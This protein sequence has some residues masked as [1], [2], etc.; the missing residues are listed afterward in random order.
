MLIGGAG[1]AR[2]YLNRPEL[3]AE[4]FIKDPFSYKQGD[5][6]YKTGDLV[7]YLPDGNIEFMGR[8]DFQVKFRGFRVEPGEIERVIDQHPSVRESVVM[9]REDV[10]GQKFLAAYWTAKKGTSPAPTEPREFLKD[11]FPEYMVP[12]AFVLLEAFPLS[13][14][15][16]VDRKA[17]PVPELTGIESDEPYVGPRNQ[18]ENV[19]AHIWS[20]VLGIKRI[21]I[22][23]NFFELGGH[24]LLTLQVLDRAHR[25]GLDL[26]PQQMFK[27]QTIGDLA[28][29]LKPNSLIN[30]EP[31]SWSSLVPLQPDGSRPPLFLIHTTPGDIL[32]YGNLVHHLG[33]DQPCYGFQS[34]G[35]YKPEQ[36][37]TSIEEMAAYYVQ[38]LLSFNPKGPTFWAAG[39]TV[40]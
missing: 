3:T 33:P 19:L 16:K 31:T 39:V 26:T 24:S 18:T 17:L 21:G 22:H 27:Y 1:V 11:K 29:V 14:N 13:P 6:L 36:A 15:G 23:D 25:E 4:R 9:L 38:L 34:L 8:T 35:L 30:K 2:G 7:R 10:P 12:A 32:G 40:E 28:A 20:E 5:R 37:Q